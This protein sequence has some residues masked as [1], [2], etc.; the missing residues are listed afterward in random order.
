MK[1]AWSTKS[2]LSCGECLKNVTEMQIRGR[3]SFTLT[4]GL[5]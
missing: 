2:N 5:T 1:V 4:K 3:K